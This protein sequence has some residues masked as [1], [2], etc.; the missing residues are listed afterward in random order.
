MGAAHRLPIAR[1]VQH[2]HPRADDVFHARARFRQRGLDVLQR[3][4]RLRVG[5]ERACGVVERPAYA[6]LRREKRS[7]VAFASAARQTQYRGESL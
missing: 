6:T 1:D 3:L 5:V 7:N 4:L 2:V